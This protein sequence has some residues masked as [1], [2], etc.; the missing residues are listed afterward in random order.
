MLTSPIAGEYSWV[1][2]SYLLVSTIMVPCWGRGESHVRDV[3]M[4]ELISAFPSIQ[5]RMS[6]KPSCCAKS[7][8]DRVFSLFSDIVGRK[9]LL[10]P[11]V[12]IFLIGSGAS[13][14]FALLHATRGKILRVMNSSRQ[15]YAVRLNP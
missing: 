3:A 14:F 15:L 1:G 2:T 5:S 11:G 8:F 6:R 4:F 7:P 13:S 12:V 9:T 10:I